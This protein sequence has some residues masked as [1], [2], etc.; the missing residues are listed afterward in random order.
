MKDRLPLA[1]A[2][3][4]IR[5]QHAYRTAGALLRELSRAVN[6]GHTEVRARSGLP[7]GSRLVLVLSTP[8]LS[9]PIEVHGTVTACR[10]RRG[11]AVMSLRYDFDPEPHRT[12][13]REALVELR[14]RDLGRRREARVPLAVPTEAGAVLRGLSATVSDASRAG[15]RI[16]LFG[17]RLPAV[18]AGDRVVLTL[19]GSRR[20]TRRPA[21]L[22]LETLWA[23][24]PRRT[25]SE[26]RQEVGG[27][28]VALSPTLRQRIG[29]ILSFDDARPAFRLLRIDRPATAKVPAVPRERAKSVK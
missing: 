20:G 7:A 1:L 19:A 26:R 18:A 4:A 25:G 3:E 13:L 23:G 17:R 24:P 5:L 10:P 22:V 27:R 29:A 11:G 16:E 21:R 9:R 14:R 12:H 2:A 8:A 15:A 6:Q 28:F